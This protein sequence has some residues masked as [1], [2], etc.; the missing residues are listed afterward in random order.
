MQNDF[1]TPDTIRYFPPHISNIE[2]FKKIA[3]IYDKTL[4]EIWGELERTERN[5]YFSTMDEAECSRWESL[6]KIQLNGYETLDDRRNEIKSRSVSGL[7]YT[8]KKFIEILDSLIGRGLYEFNMDI[9]E[10]QLNLILLQTNSMKDD[11]IYN[12]IREMAPADVEIVMNRNVIIS[13]PGN[14]YAAG[15]VSSA[16]IQTI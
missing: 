6:L 2:E 5:R 4:R 8:K 1:F 11:Y 16:F 12:L 15:T 13:I 10:K 14:L 9:P 3:A 7:P